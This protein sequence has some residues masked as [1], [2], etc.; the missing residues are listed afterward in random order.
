[1][2]ICKN[3]CFNKAIS[4]YYFATEAYANAIFLMKMQKTRG[5]RSRIAIIRNILGDSI[6]RDFEKL[7][8]YRRRADHE[9]SIMKKEQAIEARNLSVK[10]IEHFRSYLSKEII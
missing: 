7:H 8:D 9:S 6:A 4:A 5:F 3:E 1:M 2:L 10:L